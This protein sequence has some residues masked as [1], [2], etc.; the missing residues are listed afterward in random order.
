MNTQINHKFAPYPWYVTSS[1]GLM[2]NI[3]DR[4]GRIIADV[5]P[6]NDMQQEGATSRLLAMAPSL[7]VTIRFAIALLE[8]AGDHSDLREHMQRVLDRAEPESRAKP[9]RAAKTVARAVA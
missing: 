6:V 8:R 2:T 5:R 3:R 4:D 1:D 7:L 9:E